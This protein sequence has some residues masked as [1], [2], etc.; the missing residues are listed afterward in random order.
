MMIKIMK[1][2]IMILFNKHREILKKIMIKLMKIMLTV[3]MKMINLIFLM[4]KIIRR[5]KGSK[6]GLSGKEF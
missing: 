3:V 4:F 1:Y 5:N 2:N 6:I